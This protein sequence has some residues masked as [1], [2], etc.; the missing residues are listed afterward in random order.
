[1]EDGDKELKDVF[2]D[3][4]EKKEGKKNKDFLVRL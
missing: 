4:E 2:T 3:E 1:M